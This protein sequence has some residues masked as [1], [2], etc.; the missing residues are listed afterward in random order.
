[1]SLFKNILIKE[2]YT[3][4]EAMISI[5]K[6]SLKTVIVI[7][8]DCFI[9]GVCTDGNIRRG[10]IKGLDLNVPISEV[11]NKT[12]KCVKGYVSKE[13]IKE[14]MRLHDVNIIPIVDFNKK[15][16]DV[17]V[18][19]INGDLV[20]LKKE[21]T[22]P[23]ILKNI[24]VIGGAGFI[25][26]ILTRKLLKEGYGVIILDKFLYVEDSLKEIEDNPNLKIIKGDTRHIEDISKAIST[27]DAVVHLAELVGDPACAI[28]PRVTLDINYFATSLIAQICKKH[29]I[30]R[31]IY[32][33]SCSVYGSPGNDSLLSENSPLNPV[34]LYAKMKIESEK[35]LKELEDSNFKPTIF[36]LST[37]FGASPRPRFDLVVNTFIAKAIKDKKITVFGGDQWRPNIHA[38]DV[39]DAI[40]LALGAPL[41]VVGGEIFNVGSESLNYTINGLAKIITDEFSDCELIIDN[42][43]IDK[44]NYKVSFK[45]IRNKLNFVPKKSIK[46]AILE[47]GEMIE[48]NKIN[49]HSEKYHNL[50]LLKGEMDKGCL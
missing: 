5:D 38:E 45:K 32:M 34:S 8:N 25:G 42:K 39:S 19:N 20:F 12:P 27:A 17:A 13:E 16:I 14:F 46:D 43:E 48:K 11:M 35:K 23:R 4:K 40:I 30:N 26:S 24:L 36:R 49:I 21:K 33:S 18:L 37:V 47:I 6:G 44:R 2:N 50:K 31:M 7:D 10:L 9:K 1:M 3:I 22:V 15:V 29:Q 41:N 28:N